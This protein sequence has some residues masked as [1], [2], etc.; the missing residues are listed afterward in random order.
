MIGKSGQNSYSTVGS[1][2]LDRLLGSSFKSAHITMGLNACMGRT[3]DGEKMQLIKKPGI[4]ILATL[5]CILLVSLIGC[6][7]LETAETKPALQTTDGNESVIDSSE[8]DSTKVESTGADFPANELTSDLLYD[9]LLAELALQ[10]NDYDLAF[11]KYYQAAV[12]TRDS[13]LVKKATGVTLFSKND[14][15]THKS[16]KFWSELQPDN[17][18]VQQIYASSLISQK[19]DQQAIEYL[20]RVIALSEDYPAGLKRCVAILDT[21]SERERVD[22]LFAA[23]TKTELR[24]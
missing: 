19:N 24:Q 23:L 9:L 21:I 5:F 6:S 10:Q 14:A 16:V 2:F 22:Y 3:H 11:E 17:L 20:Q 18:D 13:R 15:Q 1:L 7:A 8:V 4:F 12:Q